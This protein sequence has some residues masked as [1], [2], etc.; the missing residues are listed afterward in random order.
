MQARAKWLEFMNLLAT[1]WAKAV[2]QEQIN[3]IEENIMPIN[4]VMLD[5]F[6][7]WLAD[8]PEELAKLVEVFQQWLELQGEVPDTGSTEG[9][10]R[11]FVI[12]GTVGVEIEGLS[13][14][15]LDA[16]KKHYAEGQVKERAM[17]FVKGFFAGVMLLA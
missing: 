1:P 16:V 10:P 4:Q 17:A 6:M 13:H 7:E 2:V 8:Q 11:Q 12:G 9:G 5:K 3:I 14:S 15:D